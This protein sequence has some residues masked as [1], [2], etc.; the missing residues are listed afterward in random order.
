M[1]ARVA[2]EERCIPSPP[3]DFF[4]P[5]CS[6]MTIFGRWQ[7]SQRV[8]VLQD[9][10]KDQMSRLAQH[11]LFGSRLESDVFSLAPAE[12]DQWFELCARFETF[13]FL[14][15]QCCQYNDPQTPGMIMS[16]DVGAWLDIELGLPAMR[17]QPEPGIVLQLTASIPASWW[18]LLVDLRAVILE[19]TR[20]QWQSVPLE[21][22]LRSFLVDHRNA[23]A[24]PTTETTQTP[25]TSEISLRASESARTDGEGPFAAHSFSHSAD[26]RSIG[27]WGKTWVLTTT[28]AAMIQ[29]L[30]EAFLAGMPEV[31]NAE[32]RRRAGLPETSDLRDS[33]KN[34]DNKPIW[35]RLIV[36]GARRDTKR[37]NLK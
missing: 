35:V 21:A 15:H 16:L 12:R 23:L 33:W 6:G 1:S 9:N 14:E 4:H 17:R 32:L 28:Q 11:K 20:S 37:L 18:Q 22:C 5:F 26:Y 31:S 3:A 8:Q 10:L 36:G 25:D 24:S 7:L 27:L 13:S 2:P 30:H 19:W 34:S 29:P